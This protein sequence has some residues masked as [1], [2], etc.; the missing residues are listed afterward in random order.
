MMSEKYLFR[1]I[2]LIGP[3]GSGKS[4]LGD[5]LEKKGFKGM[6]AGHFDFGRELRKIL[7]QESVRK[8][9]DGQGHSLSDFFSPSE[10][11]RIRQSVE[12]ATLFEE[13]DR[14][15]VKKIF[16]YYL[17]INQFKSEDILILNGLPRHPAQLA[18][19]SELVSIQLVIHLVCSQKTAVKRI[20]AN[21][22]GERTNRKDD[23]PEIIKRRYKIYQERTRPLLDHLKQAGIPVVELKVGQKTTPELLWNQ[24]SDLK[25]EA[26]FPGFAHGKSF[27]GQGTI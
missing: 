27:P 20:Q 15:L 6:R 13:S 11:E 23:Q 22:E 24:L 25:I 2:L 9:L 8:E 26:F 10:I 17:T 4:P 18:W 3:P 5:Y 7:E 1:A 16:R 19:I 14:Q 12:S 21:L